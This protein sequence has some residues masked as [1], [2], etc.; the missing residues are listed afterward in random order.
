[1]DSFQGV[2]EADTLK[3]LLDMHVEM[4]GVPNIDPVQEEPL[5]F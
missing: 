2:E 5:L 4:Q 1:M 3:R